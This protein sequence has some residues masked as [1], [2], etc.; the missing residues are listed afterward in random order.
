MNVIEELE[1][2][3]QNYD[4][5]KG[6]VGYSVLNRPIYYFCIK[7]S[8]RP[9]MIAAF[10]IHAR[11]YI[12]T[13]LAMEL[14]KKFKKDATAGSVYF[15]PMVNPDGV[16]IALTQKPL[17]KANA[18]GVDL[19]VNFDAKWGEGI[20]NTKVKGD[21]NYIGAK[22]FSEP[23]THSLKKFT[24]LTRPDVTLSFHSK[25][26]EIYWK[27]FQNEKNLIRDYAI[28]SRAAVSTGYKLT[29]PFG[30]VG[31]YKDWCIQRLQIPSLTIEVGSD[32]LFHPIKKRSLKSIYKKTACL[33]EDVIDEMKGII[34]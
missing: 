20:K 28:A 27:F 12:T 18:N 21:E 25:G 22:P 6:I 34:K 23:E 19:N 31:G 15:I 33:I 7:K 2:F 1:Y 29:E 4:G 9:V 24:L 30:S 11:E 32:K 26:E 8:V 13:Y 17:Y 10:S 14:I 5:E 16:N 3:Y